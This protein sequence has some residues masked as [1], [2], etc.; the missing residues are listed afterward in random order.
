ML[1]EQGVK[2]GELG[3]FTL[4]VR[5]WRLG[6]TRRGIFRFPFFDFAPLFPR[7]ISVMQDDFVETKETPE[8]K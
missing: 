8:S 3:L 4:Q 7:E 5:K 1:S 6:K 2:F